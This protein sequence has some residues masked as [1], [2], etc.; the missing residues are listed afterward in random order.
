[1][2]SEYVLSIFS[3][4]VFQA[5]ILSNCLTLLLGGSIELSLVTSVFVI[6]L[7]QFMGAERLFWMFE[8]IFNSNNPHYGPA[9][10]SGFN[11]VWPLCISIILT[12]LGVVIQRIWP[13]SKPCAD[14]ILKRLS[15]FYVVFVLIISYS[16]LFIMFG[17]SLLMTFDYKNSSHSAAHMV[18]ILVSSQW[19]IWII[20]YYQLFRFYKLVFLDYLDRSTPIFTGNFRFYVWI[21]CIENI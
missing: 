9:A 15:I 1:M 10:S 5:L 12:V 16:Y 6:L 21:C 14:T 18:T 4:L 17:Y 7:S 13:K 19:R 3:Q 8:Q 20:N 2:W 11:F